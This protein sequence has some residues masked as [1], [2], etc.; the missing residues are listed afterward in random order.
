MDIQQS[1]HHPFGINVFGSAIVRVPP[2][3]VSLTFS[4]SRLERQP[5]DSFQKAR[6]AAQK[7]RT[8]L[9]KSNIDEVQSSRIS[10]AQSYSFQNGERRFEGYQARISFHVLLRDLERMEEILLGVVDAGANEIDAI[11]FQTSKLQETRDTVRR[12]AVQAARA[13]AESYCDAADV[14]LGA[15][16]HIE[17]LNPDRMRVREGHVIRDLAPDDDEPL[18]AFDPGSIAV[19]GSVMVAFELVEP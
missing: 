14:K 18:G 6:D 5:K 17:D 1:L 4:V 8:Y 10:L 2:D 9:R 7:V 11:E 12:R 16:L 13:K 15:V 19:A 3:V